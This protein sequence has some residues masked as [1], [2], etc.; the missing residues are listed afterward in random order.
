[1]WKKTKL[2]KISRQSSPIH[3]M[4]DQTQLENA[5][6]FNY[7]GSMITN[8]ATCT[9]EIKFGIALAKQL[10]TIRRLFSPANWT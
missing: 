1:M 5:E 6:C 4:I 7:L 8:D 10:S 3:Y 9:R 2:M